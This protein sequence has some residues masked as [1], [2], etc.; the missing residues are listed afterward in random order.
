V[1]AHESEKPKVVFEE[2]NVGKLY[3]SLKT[4]W[5]INNKI[6]RGYNNS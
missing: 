5:I 4:F 1:V 3:S 2:I 6:I